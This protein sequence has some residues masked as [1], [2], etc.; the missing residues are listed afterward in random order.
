MATATL[1]DVW[2]CVLEVNLA[3]FVMT[4][5]MKMMQLS[6]AGNCLFSKVSTIINLKKVLPDLSLGLSLGSIR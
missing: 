4:Y 5:G 6:P 2:K 1:K 3:Q